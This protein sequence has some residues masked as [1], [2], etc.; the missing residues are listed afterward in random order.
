MYIHLYSQV[1][2]GF[3]PYM[4][5]VNDFHS[6]LTLRLIS[7]FVLLTDSNSIFSSSLRT[8]S[9]APTLFAHSFTFVV[10]A[11]ISCVM[12]SLSRSLT[13]SCFH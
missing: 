5:K 6:R 11:L 3:F 13:A 10:A 4:V 1:Y 2:T 7:V 12:L 9:S 8:C